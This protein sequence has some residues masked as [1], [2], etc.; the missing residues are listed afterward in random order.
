M[1]DTGG[2]PDEKGKKRHSDRRRV[3]VVEGTVEGPLP[4]GRWG[5]GAGECEGVQNKG[6]LVDRYNFKMY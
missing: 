2:N 1:D 3:L 6:R 4:K 5:E